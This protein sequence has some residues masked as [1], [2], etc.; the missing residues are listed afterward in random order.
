M[1]DHDR[2]RCFECGATFPMD[3]G[4]CQDDQQPLWPNTIAQVWRIEGII[5][6][7]T[8][9]AT[10]AAYHV[11]TGQRVAMDVVRTD[12]TDGGAATRL[13][14]RE[15]RAL[16]VMA[17]HPGVFSV[18]D[19]GSHSPR[20]QY[21]VTELGAARPLPDL[22]EE[23]QRTGLWPLPPLLVLGIGYQLASTLSTAHELGLVHGELRTQHV[24]LTGDEE[25]T[26]G[27]VPSRSVRLRGLRAIELSQTLRRLTN[28]DVRD[29]VRLLCYLLS[30]ESQRQ[31]GLQPSTVPTQCP[32]SL[33]ALFLA[34]L[35]SDRSMPALRD[36]RSALALALP[37]GPG[38]NS[39][40]ASMPPSART[41]PTA[42]RSSVED[43][44]MM[45][46]KSVG[47]ESGSGPSH[48]SGQLALLPAPPT[49]MSSSEAQKSSISGELQKVS[50]KDLLEQEPHPSRE[51]TLAESRRR[52]SNPAIVLPSFLRSPHIPSGASLPHSSG[53]SFPS[54][55]VDMSSGELAALEQT[56]DLIVPVS[57]FAEPGGR[58]SVEASIDQTLPA[59]RAEAIPEPI[60]PFANT[61]QARMLTVVKTAHGR[62]EISFDGPPA[63]GLRE[64]RPEL[65]QASGSR[66]LDRKQSA[67]R[68][69]RVSLEA[70]RVLP[71]VRTVDGVGTSSGAQLSLRGGVPLWT[72]GVGLVVVGLLALWVF[73]L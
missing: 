11:R 43:L 12:A 44:P 48:M 47:A 26:Q 38:E 51:E 49:D 30:G 53:P 15:A 73:G 59:L 7:R 42:R 72:M 40:S 60:D 32:E 58:S 25:I 63:I 24:F 34:V 21:L 57:D 46:V 33:R 70:G 41:D 2:K 8:H 45:P 22:I 10:C 66:P 5:S 56:A 52:A 18:V 6:Q 36:L 50:F 37:N 17:R 64:A 39:L 55:D 27:H 61:G 1:A 13:L 35:T 71:P 67:G 20:I 69:G 28:D 3:E 65:I 68:E 29:L 31:R 54:A 14:E 62:P 23:W 4:R 16:E 9:G 19:R